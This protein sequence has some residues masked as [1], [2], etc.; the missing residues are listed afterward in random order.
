M[1]RR[2]MYIFFHIETFML[3][4]NPLLDDRELVF[5]KKRLIK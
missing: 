4:P 2:G 1:K 3:K 5:E